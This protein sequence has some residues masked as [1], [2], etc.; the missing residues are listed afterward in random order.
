MPIRKLGK[1]GLNWQI[2]KTE[3]IKIYFEKGITKCENC[4]RKNYLDFHHRPKRSS[5]EAVHD[6]AHTRLLCLNCHD[7][8]EYNDEADYKLFTRPTR[9]YDPKYKI[10]IMAEKKKEKTTRKADW[11]LAHICKSCKQKTSF[12]I[13][14]HC[15][16]L[17]I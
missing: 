12:L 15:N 2:H 17:S 5:Q 10:N 9:G 7:Y 14:H 1:K 11:Q 3:L 16:K 6:F 4:G 8:F 13:C